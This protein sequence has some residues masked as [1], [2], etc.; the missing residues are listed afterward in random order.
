MRYPAIVYTPL[1]ALEVEAPARQEVTLPLRTDF[2]HGVLAA[3][4]PATVGGAS[5]APGQLAHLPA[6]LGSVRLR[7]P[8]ARRFLVIGGTPLGERLLMWWNFVARTGVEIEEARTEWMAGRFGD[9][10]GYEGDPLPAP[11][12]P[13]T[14]LKAHRYT[15]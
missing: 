15:E 11:P 14:P 4:G 10:T 5:I 8:E 13:P 12:L 6:G 2:E 7:A 9:V 1:L 3:D